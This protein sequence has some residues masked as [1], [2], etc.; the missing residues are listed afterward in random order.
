MPKH[1]AI[2]LT[3]TRHGQTTENR[4]GILQGQTGGHLS[5]LGISQAE[6]L[7]DKLRSEDYDLILCSDLERTRI[8]AEIINQKMHLPIEYTTLLRERDWGEYTGRLINSITIPYTLF[9]D[10]IENPQQLAERAQRFIKYLIDN[11]Q[12]KRILAI[13]HGYFNRCIQAL[14]EQRNVHDTPRWDNTEM[15]TFSIDSSILTH[16]CPTDYIVS[17]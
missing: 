17:E 4:D 5:T 13:G 14:I 6:E 12:G 2:K 16:Q 8:C 9:P 1:N 3:L 15:R 7:R 11:H 10:S